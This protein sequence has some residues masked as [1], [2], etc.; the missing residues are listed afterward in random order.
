[1]NITEYFGANC[2]FSEEKDLIE[3]VKALVLAEGLSGWEIETLGKAWNDGLMES[4]DTP[5]KGA[6]ATLLS[7]GIL[8]Q[9]CWKNN[10]YSFSVTY[11]L[12]YKVWKA[13]KVVN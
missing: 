3:S 5:S 4:G 8:C 12:G 9:T 2:E 10:D 13:L 1:M 7:K 11:P 6:R